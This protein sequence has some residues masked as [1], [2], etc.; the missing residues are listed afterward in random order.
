M[1]FLI[2]SSFISAVEDVRSQEPH[3][4][5]AIDILAALYNF[6]RSG[7]CNVTDLPMFIPFTQATV[8]EQRT[9]CQLLSQLQIEPGMNLRDIQKINLLLSYHEEVCL[10]LSFAVCDSR[11]NLVRYSNVPLK[12]P[13]LRRF[14]I[15]S[16]N[17]FQ[18]FSRMN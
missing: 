1:C 18:K 16:R 9:L 7:T 3:V 13:Q 8:D 14:L 2:L 6:E 12:I 5:L 11:L 17:D 10:I 4:N 15:G